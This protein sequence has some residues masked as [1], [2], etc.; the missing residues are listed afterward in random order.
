MKILT[1]LLKFYKF[2]KLLK[3]NLLFIFLY[4]QNHIIC[5]FYKQFISIWKF[6]VLI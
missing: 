6:T 3:M 1:N 4:L 5:H 2:I